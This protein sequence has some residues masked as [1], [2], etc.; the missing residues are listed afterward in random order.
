MFLCVM[1][2]LKFKF[3]RITCSYSTHVS[4]RTYQ[5]SQVKAKRL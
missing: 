1:H 3:R 5:A 2:H 4:L